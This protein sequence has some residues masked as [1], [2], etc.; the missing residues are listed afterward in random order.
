VVSQQIMLLNVI[1]MG[2]V[3]FIGA[4]APRYQRHPIISSIFQ[5][6]NTLFLPIV[7]TVAS[8]AMIAIGQAQTYNIKGV[9]A[10]LFAPFL[11]NHNIIVVLWTGLVIFVGIHASAVV[12]GDAREGRNIGPPFTE[13]LVKAIWVAY[14]MGGVLWAQ[15]SFFTE[16]MHFGEESRPD[17][18]WLLNK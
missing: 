18:N 3:V 15:N 17:V 8:T 7:S 14:L 2:V 5:G 9:I 13:L 1:V 12:A 11:D 4:C 6:A 16:I 10:T